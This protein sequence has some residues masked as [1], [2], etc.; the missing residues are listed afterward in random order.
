MVEALTLEKLL[1]EVE[2]RYDRDEQRVVGIMMARYDVRVTQE[3]VEQCYQYWNINSRKFFD[4]YW[5]GYGEYLCVDDQS[6]T[7]MI[8]KYGGNLHRAYFDLEA[9]IDIKEK[10]NEC[11][12]STYED[13]IQL[14][15]VNY[16]D[17]RLHFN[18]S[19]KIDLEENL[20]A[21]YAKIREIMEFV[22]NE[23][24]MAH[25]VAAIAKKIKL[26]KLKTVIKGITVSDVI[27]T[28]VE[29][30]GQ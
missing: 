3:V 13:K 21:N 11:F 7:K 23:C 22:T 14:I 24:R 10:F 2:R 29:I 16:R 12:N 30:F 26:G 8:L 17:G 18:E 27:S 28:V 9:F 15:L 1:Q 5:A 4:I 20:D 25:E 6:P 19:L